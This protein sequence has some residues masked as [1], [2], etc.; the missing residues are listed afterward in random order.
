[1][2]I[3]HRHPAATWY[4]V[5]ESDP[6]DADYEAE[7]QQC[8]ERAERDYQ[9]AQERLARA[10]RR[11]AKA[12]TARQARKQVTQLQELVALRRAEL[13]ELQRIMLAAPVVHADKQIRQRTGRDDHLELG[14]RKRP[15]RIRRRTAP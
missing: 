4:A 1:M 10:E 7:V 2:K 13:A 8:T 6:V 14:I 15:N 9:R 3:G 11:L 5:P 12:V